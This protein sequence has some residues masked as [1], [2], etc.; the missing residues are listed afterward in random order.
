MKIIAPVA[1]GGGVDLVAR[2]MADRYTKVL[3]QTFIVEN[4]SGGGGVIASQAM[5]RAAPDGYTLM[6]GYVATHGTN[7]AVRKVP[8]DAVKDFTPIAMVAARRTCSWWVRRSRCK[9]L[10][11][12]VE[13][14][15]KNR[16][17]YGSAGRARSRTSR[18]SSSSRRRFRSVHAPYRGIGPAITDVLGGQTQM[19][20][21]GLAAAIAATS[22][23]AR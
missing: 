7:P 20:M 5:A 8:Y 13:Y 18:W 14:A 16:S 2:T 11:E 1:P 4:E 3:G 12:L 21:P 19:M 9:D 17:S 23:A 10:K 6:L 22:R 15:K